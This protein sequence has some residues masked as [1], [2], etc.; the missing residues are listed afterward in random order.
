AVRAFEISVSTPRDVYLDGESFTMTMTTTDPLGEPV[1]QEV[2]VTVLKRV[3]QAGRVTER[4]VSSRDVK[5]DPKTGFATVAHKVDDEEGGRA[6]TRA[7][8]TDRSQNPTVADR[9]LT[10]SG[11]DDPTKL[12]LL[13][14]RLVLK[15]GE[16]AKV[17]L[18]SR[19]AAGTALLTWEADRI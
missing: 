11:R 1:G 18:H 17:T 2:K 10:I 15:V 12:R 16:T 4:E 19:D 8:A 5:T 14:D 6:V 9:P 7:P 13:T 3:E